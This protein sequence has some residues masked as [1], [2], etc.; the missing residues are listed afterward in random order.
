M[1]MI[2]HPEE[3]V[4]IGQNQLF[5]NKLQH[6]TQ[7]YTSGSSKDILLSLTNWIL[8]QVNAATEIS[9]AWK[10]EF[11]GVSDISDISIIITGESV[12]HQ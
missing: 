10:H 12:I 9:S 5:T 3:I 1:F 7:V 11:L 4:H 2:T 8:P 6:L